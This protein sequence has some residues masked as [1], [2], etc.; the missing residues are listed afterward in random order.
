MTEDK[1]LTLWNDTFRVELKLTQY[2][3]S[4]SECNKTEYFT[5]SLKSAIRSIVNGNHKGNV[6]ANFYTS[7][8]RWLKEI[9]V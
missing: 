5:G 7:N 2:D 1:P 9:S 8:G 3:G 4:G 6:V